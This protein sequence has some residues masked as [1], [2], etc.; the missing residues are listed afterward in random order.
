MVKRTD[1]SHSCHPSCILVVVPSGGQVR[2]G[3]G[4][5]IRRVSRVGS[6]DV[7]QDGALVAEAIGE[8]PMT[9]RAALVPVKPRR[10]AKLRL[11]PALGLRA[12]LHLSR[13]MLDDVLTA[14]L[15]S[16]AFLPVAV[17][18]RDRA[19]RRVLRRRGVHVLTPPPGLRGLNREL[20]WAASQPELAGA[21][22]LLVLPGD[23]PGVRVRDLFRLALPPLETGVRLVPSPDGG[24]NALLLVPP[25][26]VPFRFGPHSAARHDHAATVRGVSVERLALPSLT[27]DIDHPADLHA[28]AAGGG[29]RTRR[30]LAMLNGGPRYRRRTTRRTWYAPGVQRERAAVP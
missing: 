16:A 17:V 25:Q 8:D 7:A 2:V 19:L 29:A 4:D 22:R 14:L 11:R 5:F 10:R 9:I 15:D 28:G 23:V 6:T 26:V 20:T 21:D 18:T 24:T 13:A 3:A 30:V 12:R 1:E 27:P